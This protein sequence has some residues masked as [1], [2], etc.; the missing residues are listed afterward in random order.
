MRCFGELNVFKEGGQQSQLIS[1]QFHVPDSAILRED[2]RLCIIPIN[3]TPIFYLA[4]S[5]CKRHTV[6]LIGLGNK[7]S[8][9]YVYFF[10]GA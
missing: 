8:R 6:A 3:D 2:P 9:R 5:P 1:Y 7:L 10:G 4:E